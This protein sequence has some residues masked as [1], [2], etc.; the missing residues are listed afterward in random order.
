[1]RLFLW[2]LLITFDIICLDL[3]AFATEAVT[4]DGHAKRDPFVPLVTDSSQQAS[5]LLGV[6]SIDEVVI[7]GVVYDPK[8]G[9]IVIVNG[10][11]LREGEESGSVKVLQVKPDG[12]L[13]SV[14][15]AEA[16][17]T[18]FQEAVANGRES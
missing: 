16:F 10:S 13:V 5:G 4:Y 15:G 11:V 2:I 9:S 12:A 1:M 8:K 18:M 17:K 6:E 3:S 7:E 14:N